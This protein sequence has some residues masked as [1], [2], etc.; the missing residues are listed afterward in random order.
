MKVM[1]IPSII[2]VQGTVIRGLIKGL[3]D[4]EIRGRVKTI[5]MKALLRLARIL[6]RVEETCCLS[7]SNGKPSANAGV[8][9]S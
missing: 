2:G 6:K 9:N 5:Q 7:D 8:K 3:E 1:V 4:L